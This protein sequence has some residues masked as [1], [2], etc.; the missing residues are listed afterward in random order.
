EPPPE[1]LAEARQRLVDLE[2]GPGGTQGIIVMRD[3]RAEERHH[4]I[5]DML[6]DG[7]AE[8]RDDAVDE[9]RVAG[10]EVPQLL[11]I[12]TLRQRGEA[13]EIGEE[14]GDL[15]PLAAGL[16]RRGGRGGGTWRGCQRSDGGEQLLAMAERGD[17]ELLQI[18]IAELRQDGR[19][20]VVLGETARVLGK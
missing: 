7:A 16:E 14:D 6:V 2:R 17:A 3:G 20:D 5:A 9:P 11:G 10:D 1:A 18:G 4:G 8:I 15:A 13:R 12:E 19:V